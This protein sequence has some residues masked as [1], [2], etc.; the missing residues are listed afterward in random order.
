MDKYRGK[1]RLDVEKNFKEGKY[2]AEW[3]KT[4]KWMKQRENEGLPPHSASSKLS[5]TNGN[6]L[7]AAGDCVFLHRSIY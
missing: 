6:S 7:V 1:I 2:A 3:G 4:S 5:E